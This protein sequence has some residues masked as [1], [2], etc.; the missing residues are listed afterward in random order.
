MS[1]AFV[2]CLWQLE[3]LQGACGV[4]TFHYHPASNQTNVLNASFSQPVSSAGVRVRED[5]G[6]LLRFVSLSIRCDIYAVILL[7]NGWGDVKVGL[8]V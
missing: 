8:R 7:M 6:T 3:G 1:T 5:E 4:R 2:F